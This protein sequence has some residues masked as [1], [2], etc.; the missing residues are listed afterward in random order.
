MPSSKKNSSRRKGKKAAAISG[1]S[2][3]NNGVEHDAFLERAIA[4]AAAEKMTLDKAAAEEKAK[5]SI[6]GSK[7]KHGYDPSPIEARFCNNFMAKFMDAVNSAR[8]R[9]DNE[10]SLA[11]A[12]DSIFGKP[13][14]KGAKEIATIERAASFCLSVGTQNLLEGDYDCARQNASMGCFFLEIVPTVMLGTKENIDWPKVMELNYADLRTLISFY[15]KRTHHCSC[16]DKMYKEVKSMKKMG[17]CYNPECGLPN[18]KAERSTMLHCTQ[19]RCANYCSRECQ[20]ADW[21]RHRDG[22]V[23][24]AECTERVKKIVKIA[25]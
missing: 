23:E 8:K 12:F 16:L 2:N 13:C 24:T 21:P 14:P 18:R 6:A 25:S 1:A 4:L 19:C 22:C 17:I 10:H 3:N 9:H 7:C 5:E 11:E 20:A 15:R